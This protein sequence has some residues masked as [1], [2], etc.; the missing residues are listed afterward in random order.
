MN[1]ITWLDFTRGAVDLRELRYAKL[2]GTSYS[3]LT[4]FS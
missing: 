4:Q 2:A 1:C 3:R